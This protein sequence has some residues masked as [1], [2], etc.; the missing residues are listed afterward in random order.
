MR[1]NVSLDNIK[2]NLKKHSEHVLLALLL[3]FMGVG[4]L[5]GILLNSHDLDARQVNMRLI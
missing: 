1:V 3:F 5:M 2:Q 4:I